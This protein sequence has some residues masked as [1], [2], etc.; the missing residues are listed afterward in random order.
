MN[1]P[2][3]LDSSYHIQTNVTI[4]RGIISSIS[5]HNIH[6]REVIFFFVVCTFEKTI[7]NVEVKVDVQKG[8]LGFREN[9]DNRYVS[10]IQ[11][12]FTSIVVIW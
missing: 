6:E 11:F 8:A 5:V 4:R 12:T 7:K 9:F 10:S 3:G 2:W 1:Q